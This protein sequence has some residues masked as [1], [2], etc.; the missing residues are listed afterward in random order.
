M[1]N[2]KMYPEQAALAMSYVPWQHWEQ[3]Y[4]E[5]NA[6]ARGTAFPSLD[7]PL[8]G[9]SDPSE[10]RHLNEREQALLGIQQ[11]SFMVD[12]LSLYL[13]THP[14]SEEALCALERMIMR[15]RWMREAYERRYGPLTLEGV[16]ENNGTYGWVDSAWPWKME[17]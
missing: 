17:A 6:L 3:L 8:N 4:R 2:E 10:L 5:Q 9:Y 11:A 16:V 12:E 13:N 14:G 1:T 7:L 15:E